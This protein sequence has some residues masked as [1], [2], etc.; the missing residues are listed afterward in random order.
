MECPVCGDEVIRPQRKYCSRECKLRNEAAKRGHT[1]YGD[2]PFVC[3]VCDVEF[4]RERS[5]GRAPRACSPG[6]ARKDASRRARAWY[7][8]AT[9]DGPLHQPSR[10]PEYKR[11]VWAKY[12]AANRDA[13]IARSIEWARRNPDKKS[14]YDAKRYALTRGAVGAEL[15]TLDE[16]FERDHG[17]CHLCRKRVA[18]P[19]A[20]MDH[21]IPVS[22]GGPHKRVNVALAHR[23][24]NSSKK[25]AP[26]G[27]QLR[28]IG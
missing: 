15:F 22:L 3:V 24:C 19:D 12:Y 1:R 11:Q 6:C 21:L 18:R 20:T 17:I 28:L 4:T 26:M 25:A 27:E 9:A 14:S 2:G 5:A 8:E 13:Q 10:D 16:I 23:S 7:H